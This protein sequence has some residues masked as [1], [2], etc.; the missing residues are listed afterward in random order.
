MS[1]WIVFAQLSTLRGTP[2]QHL[3]DVDPLWNDPPKF[4]FWFY[5]SVA[6][7]A[8][9][10][11]A[12]GSWSP[13]LELWEVILG[14]KIVHFGSLGA[15]GTQTKPIQKKTP[16]KT[17]FAYMHSLILDSNLAPFFDVFWIDFLIRFLDHFWGHFGL[18]SGANMEPKSMKN[19]Y[20]IRSKFQSDFGVVIGTFLVNF[21]SVLESL[22]P[23][24]WSSRVGEVLF[25]KN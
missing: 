6:C 15:L 12:G 17:Y 4:E 3:F 5:A 14:A 18:I 16:K 19:R 23:Q 10:V 25:L 13:F 20:K 1:S 8:F 22:N 2:P 24:K 21:G 7:V 11:S 9:S